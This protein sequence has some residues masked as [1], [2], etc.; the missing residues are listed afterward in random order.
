MFWQAVRQLLDAHARLRRTT[1]GRR[2]HF[3]R[4]HDGGHIAERQRADA[5]A[6]RDVRTVTRIQQHNP[7]RN[8]RLHRR[9]K[10]LKRD[11]R[12]GLECDLRGNMRFLA[13]GRVFGPFLRQIKPVGDRQAGM[14]IGDRQRHHH[15]A[16]GLL[17]ELAAILMMHADRVAALLGE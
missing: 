5:G 11:L 2:A 7:A 16:V 13:A 10:L 12:L 15:L 3:D 17:A 14:M 4:R 1:I 8:I 6:Q 9:T